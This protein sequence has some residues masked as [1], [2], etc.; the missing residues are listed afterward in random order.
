MKL[1]YWA[2]KVRLHSL[3]KSRYVLPHSV[4]PS[5][6]MASNITTGTTLT[7]SH[8]PPNVLVLSSEQHEETFS[9]VK[10]C[11]AG[12]LDGERYAVY[13]LKTEEVSKTPWKENCCLLVVPPTLRTR[14]ACNRAVLE[15]V[16]SYIDGGGTLLSMNLETNS[17]F[18]FRLC[19]QQNLN[20]VQV[21]ENIANKTKENTPTFLAKLVAGSSAIT[22]AETDE[23]ERTETDV[24]LLNS[25]H[26]QIV[27]V[28][29]TMKFHNLA[30]TSDS[31]SRKT[32]EED[33][34][35]AAET[36]EEREIEIVKK[37]PVSGSGKMD[38]EGTAKAAE[39]EE[40]RETEVA[41]K[42]RVS[43]LRKM[44][45]EDTAKAA[46][47]EE[48]REIEITKKEHVNDSGKMD[49]KD[50]AKAPETEE[51]GKTEVA[52]KEPVSCVQYM[53]F[54]GS[55]GQAVLSHVNMLPLDSQKLS[56]SELVELK[57][58]A[59][60]VVDFLCSVLKELGLTCSKKEDIKLT[61]SYLICSSD[62]V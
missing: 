17:A 16:E 8:K 2:R 61:H 18:G 23:S 24:V 21:R 1:F 51:E 15:E 57:K 6:A 46:E 42:E 41:K 28:L 44:D 29:A 49:E 14:E 11:L 53:K 19:A 26:H 55:K 4:L 32:D 9:P 59:Q 34:A 31:D 33:I 43:G 27:R 25:N 60:K 30:L 56:L 37:E 54:G 52:K 50:T 12:C 3:L 58:D 10:E 38:E 20:I 40:E 47:T 22:Q 36:E 13:P 48:E 35:K 5:S 45:E 62:Q 39:T 7:G